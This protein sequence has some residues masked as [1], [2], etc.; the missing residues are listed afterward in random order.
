MRRRVVRTLGVGL[1]T[2]GVCCPHETGQHFADL[3]QERQQRFVVG[4]FYEFEIA[5]EE[6]SIFQLHTRPAGL[7]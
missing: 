3:H 1:F 2:R 5:A 7:A 6:Q 4:G